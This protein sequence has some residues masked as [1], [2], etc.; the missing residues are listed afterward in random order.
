MVKLMRHYRNY[1]GDG[2]TNWYDGKCVEDVLTRLNVTDRLKYYMGNLLLVECL[3]ES[4]S[5]PIFLLVNI[6]L[7]N[8]MNLYTSPGV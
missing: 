6:E 3:H 5:K 4:L 8:T 2:Y 7:N 1:T